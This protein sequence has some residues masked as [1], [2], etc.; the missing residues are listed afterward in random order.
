MAQPTVSE[1][2]DQFDSGLLAAE[3]E[4]VSTEYPH[5]AGLIQQLVFAGVSPHEVSSRTVR[6][7]GTSRAG[8]AKRLEN[9]ARYWQGQAGTKLTVQATG[10]GAGVFVAGARN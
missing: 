8:M 5:V 6:I 10:A 3:W 7:I 4:E 2:F 1:L 9:A